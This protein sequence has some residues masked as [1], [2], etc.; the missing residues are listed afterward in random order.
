MDIASIESEYR[1]IM[2]SRRSLADMTRLADRLFQKINEFYGTLTDENAKAQFRADY[3]RLAE[4]RFGVPEAR[5]ET[6]GGRLAALLV[7]HSRNL[8]EVEATKEKLNKELGDF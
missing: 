4:T 7:D 2:K 8:K 1:R 5:S 3:V 6:T